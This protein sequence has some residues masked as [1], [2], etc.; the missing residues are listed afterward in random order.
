MV[1]KKCDF[2]SDLHHISF[3]KTRGI[4]HQTPA[5]G[6]TPAKGSP[7]FILTV[8]VLNPFHGLG[9]GNLAKVTLSGRQIGMPQNHLADNLDGNA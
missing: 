5:F 3:L 8:P 4:S 9:F 1:R 7:L 6:V 2:D